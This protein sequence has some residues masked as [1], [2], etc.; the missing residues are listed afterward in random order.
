MTEIDL[1]ALST[2]AHGYTVDDDDDPVL[3]DRDGKG[4]D[5][6]RERYP[7]DT[8]MP[9]DEYERVQRQLRIELLKLQNWSKRTG[10]RHVIVFEG[11]DAA[12][13]GG[14]IKRFMEHLSPRGARVVAWEK[15]TDLE[16]AQWY[17]QH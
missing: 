5:T 9:R 15:P 7:Y 2:S 3:L 8:R 12:G 13:K 11:R 4:V 6:W 16:K 1:E 17:F 14:T 10:A